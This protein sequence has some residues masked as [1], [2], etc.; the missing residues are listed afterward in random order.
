ME[1][2]KGLAKHSDP[3]ADLLATLGADSLFARNTKCTLCNSKYIKEID[4]LCEN[5]KT[6]N[7]IRLFLESKGEVAP[8]TSNIHNHVTVHFKRQASAV[9]IAEWCDKMASLRKLQ[10]NR[11]QVLQMTLDAAQI[12][13]IEAVAFPTYGDAVKDKDRMDKML[14]WS[15]EIREIAGKLGEM[16]DV[17]AQVTAVKIKFVKVFKTKIE[18]AV[19]DVERQT[20][21][22]A[23]QEFKDLLQA[24]G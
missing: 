16:H 15:K 1:E 10:Q 8:A 2:E 12:E 21:I 20:Y 7:D 11:L 13:Y 6:Y 3:A 24:M 17:E 18:N 19:S 14:K 5:R 4:E 22:T 23:L 9:C